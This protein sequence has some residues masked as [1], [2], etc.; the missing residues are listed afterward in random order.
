MGWTR[1]HTL[2]KGVPLVSNVHSCLH[3]TA[4]RCRFIWVVGRGLA[5]PNQRCVNSAA[6]S[7]HVQVPGL[8]RQG[9]AACTEPFPDP[10]DCMWH[11][12]ACRTAEPSDAH[13]ALR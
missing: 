2:Q 3:P 11:I 13:S 7:H 8:E 1:K 5:V 6:I 12:R 10:P 4:G 9:T